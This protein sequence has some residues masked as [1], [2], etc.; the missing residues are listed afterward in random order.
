MSVG[1]IS[2]REHVNGKDVENIQFFNKLSA[3][4]TTQLILIFFS[5]INMAVASMSN[6]ILFLS[7]IPLAEALR[8]SNL[9]MSS[10]KTASNERSKGC[11]NSD[12]L[13]IYDGFKFED[14]SD[15][16][17][18]DKIIAKFEEYCVGQRNETFERY[19]FNMR[20]QQEGETVDAYV[21]ALKTLAKNCNFGQLQDDL[22]KDRIVI[23]IRDNT[24]RKKL[25]NMP[26]L[27]LTEC[28]DICRTHESTSKQM[29]T[30]QQQEVSAVATKA[31]SSAKPLNIAK[32]KRSTRE[33][34]SNQIQLRILLAVTDDCD[35]D[36]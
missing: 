28:I 11:L 2:G 22:L 26:K 34:K 14:D 3:Q 9:S 4:K 18:I 19:N 36:R 16:D 15:K 25:F 32:Q 8:V 17:D 6:W 24:T 12:A 30:M 7:F 35:Q 10:N 13:D 21:T 31:L 23:G 29:K 5:K 1:A 27:K 33:E 20:T